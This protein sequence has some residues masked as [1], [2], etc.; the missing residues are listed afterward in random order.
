MRS[1]ASVAPSPPD[2]ALR[3]SEYF[4]MKPQFWLGLQADYDIRLAKGKLQ[5]LKIKPH[6]R[7][8]AA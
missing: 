4:G 6:P 3:L 5:K 1:F 8:A 2:T 7:T